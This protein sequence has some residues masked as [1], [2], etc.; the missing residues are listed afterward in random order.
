MPDARL[1]LRPPPL[2]WHWVASPTSCVPLCGVAPGGALSV[3]PTRAL[4]TCPRCR[5][6]LTTA[7]A[8]EPKESV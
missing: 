5:R 4:V 3:T 6:A 8:L 7:T 1:P 2:V